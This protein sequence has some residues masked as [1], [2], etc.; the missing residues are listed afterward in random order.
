YIDPKLSV[1]RQRAVGD[2]FHEELTILSHSDDHAAPT[3][4][5]E[6]ANDF[7]DLF[8]VKD[9][10]QK[11]GSYDNRV[12]DG[13]LVLGYQRETFKRET[14]ISPSEPAAIDEHGLTF[15]VRL[16]PHGS[17]T[18]D[19]DVVAV[20]PGTALATTPPTYSRR[21]RQDEPH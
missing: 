4:H 9:A 14:T 7:A 1:I 6:P 13:K 19:I 2:R 8:E 21:N 11:L 20:L 3:I 16:E 15:T 12:E 5:I 17:W 10:L 18:T